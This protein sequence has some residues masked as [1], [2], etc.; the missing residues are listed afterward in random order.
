SGFPFR[1]DRPLYFVLSSGRP[2]D[3]DS[4]ASVDRALEITIAGWRHG[5]QSCALPTFAAEAVLRSALCLKLHAF[6]DTGAI[7][8]AATTSIPEAIGT[9]RCWDYRYCWLRD[10]AF[11]VEA[12]RRLSHLNEGEKFISF[13]RDIAESGP[14]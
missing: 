10:A 12:L 14:L 8:A 6:S 9:E 13:L 3:V 7:I 11:V 1:V 5:A 2:T 4:T